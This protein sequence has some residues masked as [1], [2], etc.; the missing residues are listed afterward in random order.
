MVLCLKTRES[1]SPPG[2]PNHPQHNK[3]PPSE[4]LGAGWSSPVARQAHNLKVTGSNPVP[5]TKLS[6]YPKDLQNP[7][8]PKKHRRKRR[9]ST[10]E[11]RGR[12]VLRK[13][14]KSGSGRGGMQGA[15]WG[16]RLW[17][18]ILYLSPPIIVR[19]LAFVALEAQMLSTLPVR[20][21]KL[22]W[23]PLSGPDPGLAK[24]NHPSNIVGKLHPGAT[25]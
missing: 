4:T 24:R 15:A 9:G 21:L 16:Q 7:V 17:V 18:D 6:Q 22:G 11:A 20:V 2:L 13:P 23:A 19:R 1:R 3:S 14:E 25:E 10:P 12:K 5:A 8:L